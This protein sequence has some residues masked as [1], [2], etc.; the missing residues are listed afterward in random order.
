MRLRLATCE[1][2]CNF[3]ALS[4]PQR[5]GDSACKVVP[6][7][8]RP[9]SPKH[10]LMHNHCLAQGELSVLIV[11]QPKAAH[12]VLAKM[13]CASDLR[14]GNTYASDLQ[15]RVLRNTRPAAS[16]R[17]S[18]APHFSGGDEHPAALGQAVFVQQ[19]RRAT[20]LA[21]RPTPKTSSAP[22]D[23]L[24]AY[25]RACVCVCAQTPKL[26]STRR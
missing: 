1:A 26:V 7:C 11:F 9:V 6:L 25:V 16:V 2:G 20:C 17:L 3:F 12:Q 24:R 19:W 15:Q 10:V 23:H 22:V 8:A 4:A 18:R 13:S 14:P 21:A 5:P